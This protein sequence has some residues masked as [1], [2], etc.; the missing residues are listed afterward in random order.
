MG[1]TVNYIFDN[2]GY[3]EFAQAMPDKCRITGG[4]AKAYRLF[5]LGEKMEFARWSKRSIPEWTTEI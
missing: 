4:M 1:V 3:T 2:R 5:Y